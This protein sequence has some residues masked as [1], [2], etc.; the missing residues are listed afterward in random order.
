MINSNFHEK[1]VLVLSFL[2]LN[3]YLLLGM[4]IPSLIIKTNF[5]IFL[6]TIL[7]FYLKNFLDNQILKIFFLIVILISLGTPLYEWDARSIWLFHAKRI[8]YDNSIFSVIDNYA[9]FSHNDYPTLVPALSASL[10]SLIGYW[11]EVFPKL[12]F[13]F[14][15]LPAL[16]LTLTLFKKTH[17]LIFLSIL[18]FV[19]G[20]YLFNGWADGLVAIYFSLSSFLMY[21]M[22]LDEENIY[23][24]KLLYLFITFSFFV[25]LT[26]IKNEG[27]A[28]LFI[29]FFSTLL[30][31]AFRKE[32]KK[33]F[34][35]IVLLSFSFLPIIF[36]KYFCYSNSIGYNDYINVDIL[37]NL[38]PRLYNIDN[39]LLISYFLFL[40]EKFL[41]CLIFF[42]ISFWAKWDVKIFSFVTIIFLMYIFILF[43]IF[44][45]TPYDLHWQ[46]D[47]TATR[48]IKSLSFLLAFFGL[49]NLANHEIKT[50]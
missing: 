7:T 27:I 48:V 2:I 44:L 3:N 32:L 47:S 21:V 16:I 25:S 31:K 10:A 36:W 42:L 18:L 37:S 43:F 39:Y 5:I 29:L 15:Y 30:I 22:F 1:I 49:Y 50:A 23:K 34:S 20:K 41:I 13:S 26:L 35:K 11:N 28:L 8:F 12:S 40:N 9:E 24:N 14:M 17:Y 6:L 19:I 4:N 45:S 38:L 33:D 46:L